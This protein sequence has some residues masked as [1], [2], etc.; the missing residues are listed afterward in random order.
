MVGGGGGG[1]GGVGGCGPG[2]LLSVPFLSSRPVL[3]VRVV[4]QS[5]EFFYY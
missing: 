4:L 1:G 3:V 2:G 5:D